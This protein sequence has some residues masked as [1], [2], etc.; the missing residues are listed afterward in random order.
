MKLSFSFLPEAQIRQFSHCKG[1]KLCFYSSVLTFPRLWKYNWCHHY[2]DYFWRKSFS[3]FFSILSEAL[4]FWRDYNCQRQLKW[5]TNFFDFNLL[6][7][8]YHGTLEQNVEYTETN[9]VLDR[10]VLYWT[11]KY[12]FFQSFMSFEMF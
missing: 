9:F 10:F 4:W 6:L 7:N 2:Q 5:N 8:K 1:R 11:L 12:T 3:D